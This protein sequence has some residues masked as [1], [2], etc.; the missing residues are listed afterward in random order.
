M[1]G[2]DLEASRV[3]K[4]RLVISQFRDFVPAQVGTLAQV[5]TS[6]YLGWPM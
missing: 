5:V 3:T 2:N 6:S 4:L 1:A